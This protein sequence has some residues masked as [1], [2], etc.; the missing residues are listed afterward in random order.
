MFHYVF[1]C[2]LEM[3]FA[4]IYFQCSHFRADFSVEFG[5]DFNVNMAA[6]FDTDF[7]RNP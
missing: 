2:E 1:S 6:D 5:A 7:G 3:I 4:T